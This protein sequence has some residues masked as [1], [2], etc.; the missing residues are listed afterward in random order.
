[1]NDMIKLLKND[2]RWTHG[3]LN[4]KRAVRP[5]PFTRMG[6]NMDDEYLWPVE[7]SK[8]GKRVGLTFVPPGEIEV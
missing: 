1:M 5:D 4:F 3:Y 2:D 8:D 6:P 7:I